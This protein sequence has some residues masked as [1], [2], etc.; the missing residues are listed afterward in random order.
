MQHVV[1]TLTAACILICSSGILWYRWG[2]WC[3]CRGHWYSL[4]DSKLSRQ[5]KRASSL[6]P[7]ISFESLKNAKREH[8]RPSFNRSCSAVLVRTQCA[9]DSGSWH[10]Y[11]QHKCSS[12]R[13]RLCS[14]PST[15]VCH[16]YVLHCQVC[17]FQ[18]YHNVLLHLAATMELCL[19]L[20]LSCP[21]LS[22]VKVEK[23]VP[24][25]GSLQPQPFGYST[26]AM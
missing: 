24:A 7:W 10:G 3:V 21:L 14:T 9:L 16:S 15:W 26:S 22:E 13:Q 4:A 19:L 20:Q 23:A 8:G 12:C 25:W 5:V 11:Q 18:K 2:H 1:F 17:L 6:D